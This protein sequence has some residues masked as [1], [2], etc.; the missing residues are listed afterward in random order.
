MNKNDFDEKGVV[1]WNNSYLLE[2]E[3]TLWGNDEVPIMERVCDIFSKNG[4]K[5][6]LYIPCGDGRN[7]LTLSKRLSYVIGADS[8][9]NALEIAERKIE[10][11]KLENIV[12][13]K[14]DIFNTFF[15]GKQFDG[16]FCWDLLGHLVKVEEAIS[17]LKRILKKGGL[18]LG[19]FFTLNDSTRVE[20]SEMVKLRN[21][22]YFYKNEFYFRYYSRD[23]VEKILLKEG[24]LIESIEAY[25]WEEPPHEGYRE[26]SHTHESWFFIA[27]KI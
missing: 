12:L 26:Y 9:E 15:K 14:N 10:Q 24:F 17:E 8:S 18:L 27:K 21:E 6:F 7:L 19:S 20:D 23:E 4:G 11:Y 2:K 22:E 13:L 3:D 5:K 16:I 25:S 1:N